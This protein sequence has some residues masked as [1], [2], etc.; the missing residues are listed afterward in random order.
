MGL[1]STETAGTATGSCPDTMAESYGRPAIACER[2]AGHRGQHQG[3]SAEL[4]DSN[5]TSGYFYTW[6]ESGSSGTHALH[7]AELITCPRC[8]TAS[9]KL[10]A[11]AIGTLSA[12]QSAAVTD[13][14]GTGEGAC[15]TCLFWETVIDRYATGETFVAEGRAYSFGARG[16]FGDS[17]FT[18]TYLDGRVVDRACLWANGIVPAEYREALPDNATLSDRRSYYATGPVKGIDLAALMRGDDR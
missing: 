5:G 13:G 12:A 10:G 18:V 3:P 1:M 4:V 14:T 16:G 8:G 2:E 15:S 9:S 6:D 7:V 11:P 17:V